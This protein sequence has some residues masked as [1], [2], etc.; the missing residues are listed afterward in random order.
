MG[1]AKK[2]LIP[3][4]L[5]LAS[6]A[7]LLAVEVL[8]ARQGPP[9]PPH[10]AVPIDVA[11]G[12]PGDAVHRVVWLGDST[13]AGLGA[14]CDLEILPMQVAR[15]L[16]EPVRLTDL[17]HSGDRVADVLHGQLPRAA[18]HRPDLVFISI[19][20]ND[21][22][23][24][25]PRSA[26]RRDYAAVLAGV[27]ASVRT[28]V[29]LGIPDMGTSPRI[30]QPLLAIAGVRGRVMGADVRALA[31]RTPRAIYVDIAGRTGTPFR[32]DPM[33][34]FAADL[35]HPNDA[36]YGLWARAVA[37]TLDEHQSRAAN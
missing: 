16:G 13:A 19:G 12:P 28:V 26:F 36:G 25:T 33:R 14:S 37:D 6:S 7:G 21:V 4:A 17:G 20:A 30:P 11:A 23:H 5:A 10:P 22:T 1:G 15:L 27:P 24:L 34:Y 3:A 2:V 9:S 18:T 35:Y 31:A 32:E 29:V 8:I